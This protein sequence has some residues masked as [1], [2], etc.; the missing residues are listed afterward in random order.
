[1]ESPRAIV[2]VNN[3]EI[4]IE[5]LQEETKINQYDSEVALK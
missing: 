5:N 1:M 3:I 2:K 4:N